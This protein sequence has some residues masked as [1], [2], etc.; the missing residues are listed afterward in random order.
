MI[1]G[2]DHSVLYWAKFDTLIDLGLLNLAEK[3]LT[4]C[5]ETFGEHPMILQRLATIDLAKG[6]SDAARIYLE[7]LRQT[8]FFSTWAQDYLGRLE[9]DPTLAG[10]PE[11]QQLRAQSLRK[12]STVF[13]YAREPMLT[14]LVEQGSSNRMAFEYLMAW[15]MMTKQLD[16]FVQ[17]LARLAEFGYAE[18]PLLYQEAAVIYTYGTKK[19][20]P[21]QGLAEA[22]RRI[23]HFSS[24]FNRY[25]RNKDAALGELARDYAGSYFF[26]YIYASASVQK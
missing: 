26:Y 12:D 8:L 22:Q 2:E 18:V 3:D 11:I 23:E 17:N 9:A 16:R 7:R 24:V 20:V 10:D 19:P 5:M 6:K 15:Y 1:T 14:A 25:G 21:L 4:E 13:F